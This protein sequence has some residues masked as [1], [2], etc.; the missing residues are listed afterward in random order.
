MQ[1]TNLDCGHMRENS[2]VKSIQKN[3]T[4]NNESASEKSSQLEKV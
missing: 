2:M 4:G 3:Y 1:S